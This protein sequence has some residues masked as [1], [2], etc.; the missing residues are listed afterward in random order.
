MTMLTIKLQNKRVRGSF[1]KIF[2]LFFTDGFQ[3]VHVQRMIET[4]ETEFY[5]HILQNS[6]FTTT[7]IITNSSMEAKVIWSK[8]VRE[9]IME[10]WV[11]D[12][13]EY[14][15]KHS[16]HGRAGKQKTHQLWGHQ[17]V[18]PDRGKWLRKYHFNQIE[19]HS[20]K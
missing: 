3:L 19:R 1:L 10:S 12:Y 13:E 8:T 5:S 20:A 15:E 4:I 9:R 18:N 7:L 17:R 14:G 11:E 6:H 16:P 2:I